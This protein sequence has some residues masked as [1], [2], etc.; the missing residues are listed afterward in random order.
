MK[1]IHNVLTTIMMIFVTALVWGVISNPSQITEIDDELTVE[2]QEEA[3]MTKVR[4]AKIEALNEEA[5]LNPI[6]RTDSWGW[7]T[8][9]YRV[10]AFYRSS[11]HTGIDIANQR[12]TP[13]FAS[14]IGTVVEMRRL[15]SGYGRYILIDHNNG[16]WT[17]YAHLQEFSSE[18]EIGS[19][20]SRGQVIGYIGCTGTCTGPHLHFEIRRGCGEF[21]CHVDPWPYLR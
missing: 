16:Y 2:V 5:D 3:V 14:N 10:T 8:V 18:I 19:A 15:T 11:S 13:V 12:G 6:G 20:V 21:R 7:P 1:V 4:I 17:L 9:G